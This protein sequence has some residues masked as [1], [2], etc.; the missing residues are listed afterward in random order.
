MHTLP[1]I[2]SLVQLIPSQPLL[3]NHQLRNLSS[4]SASTA[5]IRVP[6]FL[7]RLVHALLLIVELP[8]SMHDGWTWPRSKA[9]PRLCMDWNIASVWVKVGS[10]P[11]YTHSDFPSI[12]CTWVEMVAATTPAFFTLASYIFTPVVIVAY[13]PAIIFLKNLGL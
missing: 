11:G 4:R 2:T 5:S 13:S 12:S 8:I 1:H 10:S 6:Y 9:S 3:E 7:L